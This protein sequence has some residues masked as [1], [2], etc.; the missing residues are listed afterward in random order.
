MGLGVSEPRPA[1]GESTKKHRDGNMQH[2][3]TWPQIG[4][5]GQ[6]SIVNITIDDDSYLRASSGRASAVG[7]RQVW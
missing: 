7:L 4:H 3:R 2:M 1:C 6:A 5:R